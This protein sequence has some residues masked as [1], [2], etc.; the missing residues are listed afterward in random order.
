[1]VQ[2]IALAVMT[3]AIG[4]VLL[5]ASGCFQRKPGKREAKREKRTANDRRLRGSWEGE[6][7]GR[8]VLTVVLIVLLITAAAGAAM[9]FHEEKE[10]DGVIPDPTLPGAVGDRKSVV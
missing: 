10:R 8:I 3:F 1:M 9:Y 4:I 5:I 2:K 6:I 7:S